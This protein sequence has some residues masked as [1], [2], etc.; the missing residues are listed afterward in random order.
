MERDAPLEFR[1]GALGGTFV[2]TELRAGRTVALDACKTA[3]H[4]L[5]ESEITIPTVSLQRHRGNPTGSSPQA[6]AYSL[7]HGSVYGS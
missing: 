6:P 1:Y 7:L 4:F 2:Q 5:F 3:W